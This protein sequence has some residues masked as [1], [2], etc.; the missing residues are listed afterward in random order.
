[1]GQALVIGLLRGCRDAGVRLVRGRRVVRLLREGSRITG[2]VAT[3]GG[4]DTRDQSSPRGGT[5]RGRVRVR[6]GDG[7]A[8]AGRTSDAAGT[9][10]DQ[11]RGR[12]PAGRAG[13]R[14]D[15]PHVRGLVPP[16]PRPARG[17]LARRQPTAAA[18]LR[19]TRP[20]ARDLG[21]SAR[22]PV[23]QRGQPQLRSCAWRSSTRARCD[24]VTTRSG[25]SG[26]PNIAP[27]PRSA[28]S[29]PVPPRPIGCSR[30]KP[31]PIWPPAA[32]SPPPP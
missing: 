20:A 4:G 11:P 1:M 2:V 22:S 17:D 12:A 8:A 24:C 6:P 10:T 19:R 15:H 16:G 23:R 31:W 26:T 25:R 29:S 21:G 27:P 18:R 5:R 14:A 28:T 13:G 30:R 3:R 9:S 7:A 32:E